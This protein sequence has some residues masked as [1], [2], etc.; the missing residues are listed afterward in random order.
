MWLL[1]LLVLVFRRVAAL[2][3]T[4]VADVGTLDS[5]AQLDSSCSALSSMRIW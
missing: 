4:A 3:A 1:L 5:V 2:E